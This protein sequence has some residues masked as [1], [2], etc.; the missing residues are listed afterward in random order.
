VVRWLG[1]VK[2]RLSRKEVILFLGDGC[3][4]NEVMNTLCIVGRKYS[5]TSITYVCNFALFLLDV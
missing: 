2:V 1:L 5:Q 4:D 3:C